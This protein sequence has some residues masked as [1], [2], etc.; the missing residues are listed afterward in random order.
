MHLTLGRPRA[1]R[2]PRDGVGGVLRR[3]RVEEL[4]ARGQPEVREID[5]QPAREAQSLVD[6]EG[7]VEPRVVDEAFPADRG[8][9]LFEVHAHHDAQVGGVLVR[10]ALEAA[11]VVDGGDGIVDR[12]RAN[13]HDEPVVLAAQHARDRLAAATHRLRAALGERKLLQQDRR[14]QQ[15]PKAFDTQVTGSLRHG[16]T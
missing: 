4:A 3:D 8:A 6:R 7:A 11:C 9:R 15:R 12:A 16:A 1:D 2:A 5:E 14:R 10:G 13:H